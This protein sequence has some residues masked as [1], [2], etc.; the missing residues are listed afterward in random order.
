MIINI[1]SQYVSATMLLLVFKRPSYKVALVTH[2][3]N[4]AGR[5]AARKPCQRE[6]HTVNQLMGCASPCA[7][8]REQNPTWT[9]RGDPDCHCACS[10]P[11]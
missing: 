2:W 9:S 3:E 4:K 7:N 5:I 8:K 10:F 11:V 6:I 1:N